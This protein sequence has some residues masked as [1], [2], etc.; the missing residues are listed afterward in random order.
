M[1]WP[2]HDVT[3]QAPPLQDYNL[4][5]ADPALREA[6]TRAGGSWAEEQL[7]LQGAEIGTAASYEQGRLANRNTPIL[8]TF[9]ARGFRRDQIEFHPA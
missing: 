5:T 9:D 6:L 1:T 4:F 2:T 8:H 7:T 3:N